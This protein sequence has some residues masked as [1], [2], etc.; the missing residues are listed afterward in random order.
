VAKLGKARLDV[1]VKNGKVLDGLGNPPC[2][3]NI[4]TADD[5]IAYLGNE[6]PE[7]TQIIDASGKVVTPGFIDIHTHEDTWLLRHP[8]ATE[9]LSDGVTTLIVGNCGFSVAPLLPGREKLIRDNSLNFIDIPCNWNSMDDYLQRLRSV[10]LGVNVST[11]VGHNTIRMNIMGTEKRPPTNEELEQ[12]KSLIRTAME[13]GALGLSTG[14]IYVPGIYSDTSELVELTK[15]VANSH[16]VYTSHIRGEAST[17]RTAVT[18]ALNVGRLANVPLEISHHKASGR[19]NWG[20]VQETLAMIEAARKK[21]VDVHCDVYPYTAGNTGLGTL[22]PSWVFSDGL[23][24]ARSRITNPETRSKIVKEMMTSKEDEERPLVDTGA[25]NILISYSEQDSSLEGKNLADLA[26]VHQV[27]PAEI[28]LDLVMK[29]GGSIYSIFIILFEMSEQDVGTVI[30]HPLSMIASDSLTPIGRPHP[31]AFGTFSRVLAK[32]VRET[33]LLTLEE[34]VRKMTSMPASKMGL[35]D[36]GVIRVGN[37]ADL[38]ILDS[39]SVKDMA[40]F[41][42]PMRYSEGIDYVLVNGKVAWDHNKQTSLRGGTVL[43]H[44]AALIRG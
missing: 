44:S 3:T 9:K 36:R 7:A 10:H 5:S 34:A 26:E 38:A 41:Q 16:G 4:G 21:G 43:R 15:V 31:R 40:T 12:M 1:L 20:I 37:K 23:A 35:L 29:H 17:L 13:E 24:E 11:L 42:E 19:E 39:A 27:T 2:R 32:Y 8:D 33:K 6:Q 18:E 30:R 22:I 25:E 28:V 14:L